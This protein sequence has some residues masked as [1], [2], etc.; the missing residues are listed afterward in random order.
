MVLPVGFGETVEANAQVNLLSGKALKPPYCEK[1]ARLGAT[2]PEYDLAKALSL[3]G[4][5]EDEEILQ[6]YNTL[7]G[8]L[9][10]AYA[11]GRGI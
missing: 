8:N 6:K 2:H 7:A 1:P 10:A 3:A 9:T 11:V 4:A 5:L